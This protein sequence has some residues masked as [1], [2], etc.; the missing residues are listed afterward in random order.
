MFNIITKKT[1]NTAIAPTYIKTKEIDTSSIPAHIKKP[2]ALKKQRM[3]NKMQYNGHE[4]DI[5][6]NADN[7]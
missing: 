1:N 2:E 3:R 6:A 5:T 4:L 7:I